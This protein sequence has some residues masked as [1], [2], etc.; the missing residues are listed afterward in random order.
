MISYHGLYIEG[1]S[2]PGR[3][4]TYTST[5]RS[6]YVSDGRG[7]GAG[8]GQ[9][10]SG[11]ME[12]RGERHGACRTPS[13]PHLHSSGYLR[14]CREMNFKSLSYIQWFILLKQPTGILPTKFTCPQPITWLM[15]GH[16]HQLI[17]MVRYGT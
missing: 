2:F 14:K 10:S 13:Y 7:L 3:N 8:K 17:F 6:N 12:Q 9:S 4:N 5:N 1:I 15:R 11:L 16:C